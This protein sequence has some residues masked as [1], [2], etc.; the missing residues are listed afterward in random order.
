MSEINKILGFVGL[1]F[2]LTYPFQLHSQEGE[3]RVGQAGAF[4]LL[5][6]PWARSSG[7]SGANTASVRGIESVYLNVAGLTGTNKTEIMFSNASWFGDISINSF[8][9]AQKVGDTGVMGISFMSLDFGDIMITTE[10]NPNG[11]VGTYSPQFMNLAVSYAKKFTNRISGGF[12]VKLISESVANLSANGFA[13]DTGIHYETGSRNQAKFGITLKNIGPG[14]AFNGDGDDVTLNGSNGYDQTYE[15]RSADFD[16]P[17]LLN[18]G[19]SY[20]FLIESDHRITVSGNFTSNSF[21]KDQLLFG[22]EYGYKSYLMLRMGYSYE[23]GILNDFDEGRT[24][25]FTGFST[26]FSVEIPVSEE[27]S[28]FGLDYSFRPANPLS[29]VHTIGARIDL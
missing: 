9:V 11:G 2:L 8:G 1:I 26:G 21:S 27:G 24:T 14:M 25:A 6:N 13:F 18:I 28:S 17:S 4:E 29:S 10:D 3:E 20:D 19:G 15:I 5:I 12:S 7:L 23:K 22:T 16:L